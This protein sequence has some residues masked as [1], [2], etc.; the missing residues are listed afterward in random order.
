[1]KLDYSKPLRSN[2]TGKYIDD[3]LTLNNAFFV[4]KTPNIYPQELVLNRTSESDVHVSYLDINASYLDTNISIN[5]NTLKLMYIIIMIKRDNFYFKIINSPFLNSNI[6]ANQA[7]SIY[8]SQYRQNLL[9]LFVACAKTLTSK[10]V[11]QGFWYHKILVCLSSSSFIVVIF[12]FL[13]FL[14]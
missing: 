3:L 12:N 4:N 8:M 9:R 13:V 5:Q 6:P 7:Y 11:N 1:M 14:A 2:F 10:L